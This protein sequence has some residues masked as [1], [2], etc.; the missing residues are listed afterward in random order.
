M[1]PGGN[2]NMLNLE[3]KKAIV[4]EVAEVAANAQSA[5]AA[6]Y[7]G[8]TVDEMTALRKEAR[9]ADVYLRVVKN[10]LARRA[11]EGTDYACL[12]DTLTGPLMLAFSNEDPAAAARIFKDFAKDHDKLV[13]R[14][15]ALGGK[16]MDASQ[17]AILASM[18]TREQALGMLCGVIQAPISKFVR[19]L[20]EPNNKFARVM[21][22]VR[23]TKA[24]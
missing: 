2:G 6:E 22:A 10:T 17:L 7:R 21:G 9:G 3:E 13:V 15:I 4:A 19:T 20:A 8:L 24:A 23:D 5:I 16:L 11:V 18:P 12:Q 14:S 1:Q